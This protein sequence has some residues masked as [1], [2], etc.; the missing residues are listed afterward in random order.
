MHLNNALGFSSQWIQLKPNVN[1]IASLLFLPHS[2]FHLSGAAAVRRPLFS[3]LFVQLVRRRGPGSRPAGQPHPEGAAAE[4]PTGHQSGE[5]PRVFA[6][7]VHQHPLPGGTPNPNA[8]V[9][10]MLTILGCTFLLRCPQHQRIE[11]VTLL[12]FYREIR[13]PGG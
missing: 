3:G 5:A 6:A 8:E 10:Q 11:R 12:W 9:A 7:A 4:G 2:K 13:S 1:W